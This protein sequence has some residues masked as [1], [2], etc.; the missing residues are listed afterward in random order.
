VL[1][2]RVLVMSQR[3]GRIVAD[4]HIGLARPRTVEQEGTAAFLGHVK[5][6]RLALH[7]GAAA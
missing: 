1:S 3:P 7:H 2:D 4:E 6:V 5:R